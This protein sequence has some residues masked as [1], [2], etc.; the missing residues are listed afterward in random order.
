MLA[1]RLSL[2][3]MMDICLFLLVLLCCYALLCAK[4][5]DPG[6][7]TEISKTLFPLRN[8]TGQNCENTLGSFRFSSVALPIQ[9]NKHTNKQKT[10]P[11]MNIIR[12]LLL[13]C[14]V[15]EDVRPELTLITGLNWRF[16]LKFTGRV[17]R[18]DK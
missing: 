3:G 13:I 8:H 10:F 16:G 11:F 5:Q 4:L 7:V 9:T 12:V 1:F 2:W 17:K 18:A 6:L 14:P 15:T